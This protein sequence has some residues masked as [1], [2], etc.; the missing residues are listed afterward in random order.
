MLYVCFFFMG[1]K[2][3]RRKQWWQA[4][5]GPRSWATTCWFKQT[6]SNMP[7]KKDWVKITSQRLG[8]STFSDTVNVFI[9]SQKLICS[10]LKKSGHGPA[11]YAYCRKHADCCTRYRFQEVG[12]PNDKFLEVHMNDVCTGKSV[13]T[14][15]MQKRHCRMYAQKWTPALALCKMS[16]V[17][18]PHFVPQDQRPGVKSLNRR[19]R[20]QA[21]KDR[22]TCK[23]S[24]L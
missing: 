2:E 12:S 17:G 23:V 7:P 14:K 20:F 22:L 16:E 11:L 4:S 9:E 24:R 15:Y 1:E 3:A 13:D 18:T 19:R 10:P 6:S 21:S 8:L 5:S